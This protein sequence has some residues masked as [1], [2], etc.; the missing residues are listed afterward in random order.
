MLNIKTTLTIRFMF[1]TF[2][3]GISEMT[4]E[5]E[6]SAATHYAA[7]AAIY[8]QVI[9]FPATFVPCLQRILDYCALPLGHLRNC[10]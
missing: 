6:R 2:D 8:K 3:L 9:Y 7:V 1:G 5:P 10:V 4:G